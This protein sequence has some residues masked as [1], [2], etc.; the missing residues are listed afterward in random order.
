MWLRNCEMALVAIAASS[1]L[2]QDAVQ[3]SR[4]V[5]QTPDRDGVYYTGPE[6][7]A[8]SLVRTF[9]VPYP[10]GV[11]AKGVQGMTVMAMVIDAR[12]APQHIQV[13]RSHGKEFDDG[14]V[15]AVQR[16]AFDPG[17]LGDKPVPVW[18]D[19]RVV[20]HS[21]R[22]QAVPQVLI[23]ERDLPPPDASQLEDKHHRPL[24]YTP[25]VPIHT[26]DADFLDPFTNHPFVQVA[27]NGAGER[28]GIAGGGSGEA[29]PWIWPG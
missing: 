20:F 26:V 4:Q 12:G 17:K 7:S 2:A 21:N 16:S 23:A 15:A 6:V 3:L 22:S 1:A 11:P 24:S 27:L 18:I 5:H 29:R 25:P 19:V 8:P 14:A 9:T 10:Y 28:A 13:L